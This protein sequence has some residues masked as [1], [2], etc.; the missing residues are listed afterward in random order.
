M[1]KDLLPIAVAAALAACAAAPAFAVDVT[2]LLNSPILVGHVDLTQVATDVLVDVTLNAGYN[3]VDTGSHEALGY[4]ITGTDP[5]V[6]SVPPGGGTYSLSAGFTQ[7][8]FGSF[9]FGVACSTCAGQTNG[10][11]PNNEMKFTLGGAHLADFFANT[12]GKTFT[13]DVYGPGATGGN[14]TFP[15]ASGPVPSIPE[16]GTYALMLAGLGVVGFMARRRRQA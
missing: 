1:R 10:N 9:A 3:F 5:V 8:G 2:V 7:S 13:V 12:S 15:D 14:A 6:W 11:S 16:P 4:N